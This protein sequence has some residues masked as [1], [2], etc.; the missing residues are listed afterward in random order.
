MLVRILPLAAAACLAI[1]LTGCVARGTA[2]V[3]SVIPLQLQEGSNLVEHLAPDG[4]QGLVIEGRQPGAPAPLIMTMLPRTEGARGW[5]VVEMEAADGARTP[6]LDATGRSVVFARAKVGGM[7]ATLLFVAEPDPADPATAGAPRRILL[8]TLR[9][10]TDEN[11]ARFE[12]MSS[13]T[14]RRRYCSSTDA[15]AVTY[16]MALPDDAGGSDRCNAPAS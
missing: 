2:R 16:R 3:T 12:A 5:D 6:T 9:L 4:R 13:E 11:A 10:Q 7:P 8:R 1:P 14:T 15:L